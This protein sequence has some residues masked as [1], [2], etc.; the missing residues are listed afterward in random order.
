MNSTIE[1]NKVDFDSRVRRIY[2]CWRSA[3]QDNSAYSSIAVADALL[4]FVGDPSPN[5]QPV[6][7][8]L[9][10]R[11]QQWLLGYEFPSTFILFEEQK[12]TVLCS[13]SKAK[14]LSQFEGS[15]GGLPFEILPLAKINEPNNDAVPRF[16]AQCASKKR[17]GILREF[18]RGRLVDQWRNLFAN[19]TE[20]TPQFVDIGPALSA[21]IQG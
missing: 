20:P 1:L 5:G 10:V 7:E 8:P 21:I 19:T 13:S 16:F 3:T 9:G 14:V 18:H 11:F 17:L 12:M 15:L 6:T 2:D 4:L